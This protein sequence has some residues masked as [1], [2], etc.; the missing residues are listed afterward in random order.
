MG[1][2]QGEVNPEIHTTCISLERPL[3]EDRSFPFCFVY[4][5]NC[6]FFFFCLSFSLSHEVLQKS[7][8]CDKNSGR[9]QNPVL[10]NRQTRLPQYLKEKLLFCRPTW[11]K[12]SH[13]KQVN[14]G[15]L[16]AHGSGPDHWA[17]ALDPGWEWTV[18]RESS[19]HSWCQ[20]TLPRHG[21]SPQQEQPAQFQP[22]PRMVAERLI[23]H[24]IGTQPQPRMCPAEKGMTSFVPFYTNILAFCA[25]RNK[26]S[27]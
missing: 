25:R 12:G 8:T 22:G 7:I 13:S 6:R 10:I 23:W 11:V 15:K 9:E 20:G 4:S 18:E 1:F 14:K 2:A 17:E 16:Q 5:E 21:S 3:S 24:V 19:C 27:R 26:M